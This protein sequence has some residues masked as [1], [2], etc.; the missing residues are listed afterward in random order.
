MVVNRIAIGE[1]ALDIQHVDYINHVLCP[2]IFL[3]CFFGVAPQQC[4]T[5]I[6][7]RL[8]IVLLSS[9]R[10]HFLLYT[11][12]QFI[13]LHKDKRYSPAVASRRLQEYSI[14]H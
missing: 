1:P 4:L 6:N 14:E 10:F 13:V 3:P 9:M 8:Q 7:L 2:V 12:L 11:R 5:A